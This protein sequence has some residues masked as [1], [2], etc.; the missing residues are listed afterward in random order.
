MKISK[1]ITYCVATSFAY[2][3]SL[4]Q[5]VLAQVKPRQFQ[6]DEVFDPANPQGGVATIKGFEAIFFNFVAVSLSLAGIVLFITIVI[7]GFKY[8]TAG[9]N[10]DNAAAARQTLTYGFLGFILVVAAFLI[11]KLIEQF[12]GVKV[13]VFKVIA[14]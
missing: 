12:T 8:L 10:Q 2:H 13:T 7:G 6:G 11:L 4:P 14:N 9:D 5:K 3:L 1:L